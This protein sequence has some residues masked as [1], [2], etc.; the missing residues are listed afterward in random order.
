MDILDQ[1]LTLSNVILCFAIVGLVWAQR[2]IVELLMARYNKKMLKAKL[3]TEFFVPI[4]P[5]GTGALLMLVPGI[6][7]IEMFAATMATK[8]L[9]GLALGM[10]S[11]LVFRLLKKMIFDRAGMVNEKTDYTKE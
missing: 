10:V 4:A 3:W 2:K 1:L 6:P 7:V 5:L 11:G 9:F 8:M